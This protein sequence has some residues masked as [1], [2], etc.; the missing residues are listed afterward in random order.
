M[1]QVQTMTNPELNRALAELMGWKIREYRY[2]NT[3]TI[4]MP[5]GRI[6]GREAKSVDE[7]WA[8]APDYCTDPAASQEVEKAAIVADKQKYVLTLWEVMHPVDEQNEDEEYYAG[9]YVDAVAE[10]LTASPRERAEA[11]YITLQGAVGDEGS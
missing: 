11:A 2:T 7:A 6:G 5:N 10:F 1:T 4:I 8:D 3:F 9:W